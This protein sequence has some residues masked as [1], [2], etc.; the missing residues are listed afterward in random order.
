MVWTI[1]L[2]VLAVWLLASVVLALLI[3]R[4]V[5]LADRSH[6]RAVDT[7]MPAAPRPTRA[8]ALAS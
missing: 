1:V 3:G 8:R 2:S 4:A 6:R 7:R 5:K